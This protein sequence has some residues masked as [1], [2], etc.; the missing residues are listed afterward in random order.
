MP[1][2]QSGLLASERGRIVNS[3]WTKR[4]EKN[5]KR[6]TLSTEDLGTPPSMWAGPAFKLAA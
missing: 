1:K 5:P 6:M 2:R 4:H 3:T